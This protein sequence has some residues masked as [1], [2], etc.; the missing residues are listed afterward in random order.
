MKTQSVHVL[1]LL[2]AVT[3]FLSCKKETNAVSANVSLLT[4]H[5]WSYDE[6]GIDQNLDG[7]I[8]IPESIED[9]AMDDL[10]QFN[11]GGTGSFDQGPD[12]CYPEFP[13]SS[14]FDW[15]F[16]N[17]ETQIEYGGTVHHILALDDSQ[18]AIYTEEMEG[19]ATIRHILVYKH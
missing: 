8:D 18:L 4:G 14:S 16:R 13:Q 6:F 5:S 19:S 3:V 2:C 17:S 9:C 11:S 10:V 15:Q 12:L 1:L 7:N